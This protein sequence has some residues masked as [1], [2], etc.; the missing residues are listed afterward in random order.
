MVGVSSKIRSLLIKQGIITDEQWEEARRE[1]SDILDTLISRGAV[2]E[3]ALMEI[4]GRFT[5][6]VPVDLSRVTPDPSALE[7][8]PPETCRQLGVIPLSK[9]GDVLTFAVPDPFDVVLL[10][11]LKRMTKCHVRTVFAQARMIS[12]ILDAVLDQGAKQVA[13]MMDEVSSVEDVEVSDT[14]ET[15]EDLDQVAA[16]GGEAPAVKLCNLILLRALKEKASDIHIEPCERNIQVRFRVDGRMR[17]IMTPPKAILP[18]LTS[19]LKILAKLD[20][21]ERNAPQ[22]GKFQIRFEGRRVDFR[23]SVLPVVGGEKSVIR[24][25][26]G[27]SLAINLESMGYEP[28]AL[29]DIQEAIAAPYG[30]FLVTGPTGSGKSTTLYS[31]VRE[32][33][34]PEV[35]ITTVEDPVEYRMD[36]INQVAVNPKRGM[37]FAGALRSILRQ[38]PDIVLLGE[39]RDKETADIAVKAALTGH[40]VLSTL[41]TN[42]AAS[43]ITRLMDMGIDPF[44]VSS[45]LLCIC[46]QRL[47]RKLCK[48]CREPID[49]PPMDRLRDLG[50]E[51]SDITEDLQLYQ[52]NPDGCR[53]CNRG[54]KGRFPILETLPISQRLRRMIVEGATS[55]EMKAQSELE[56]MQSLRR[57]GVQNVIRGV[58]SI[59]EVLR[60]TL[61]H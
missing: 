9:V 34:S 27:Q 10:D 35:N 40:L 2:D 42:D 15:P 52:A 30:M 60:I 3:A 6:V 18:A 4:F 50:F 31:C 54:Y 53:Q 23:L 47:G 59:E 11:D 19:R 33:A 45:S 37:T 56:G 21:A 48:A 12:A 58:T 43:T 36:G 41:H 16:D 61:A 49:L 17:E 38:D 29:R 22:D 55:D 5:G 8:I 13:A 25:L 1:G 26:D 24:I 44:L 39:I 46:A 14:S 20:I 51:D 32:V 57:V 28:Q 7:V